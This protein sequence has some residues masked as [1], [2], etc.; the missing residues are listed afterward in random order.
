MQLGLR[1][2]Q[3]FKE[4]HSEIAVKAIL[5]DALYGEAPFLDEASRLFDQVQV[6]SQL[7]KNQNIILK[8]PDEKF[9]N[10]L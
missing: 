7:R 4:N 9:R 8:R 1:L 2:L 3:E 10:V 5:A 6:I